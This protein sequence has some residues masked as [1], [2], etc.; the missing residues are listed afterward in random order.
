MKKIMLSIYAGAFLSIAILGGIMVGL[1]P[2]KITIEG[3][4][5]AFLLLVSPS[6]A[7]YL[8]LSNEPGKE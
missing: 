4:M 3:L 6:F 5:G 8:I 2:T 1:E 7:V